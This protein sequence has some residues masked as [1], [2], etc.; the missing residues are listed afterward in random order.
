[1]ST[2][3]D[4]FRIGVW[5]VD[6]RL[7]TLISKD[8][9]QRLAPKLMNLLQQLALS[10]GELV[11][12]EH[13]LEIVW[14]GT[15][16]NDEVVSRA[17]AELRQALGDDAKQ[18][19]F[20]E[21]IPKRGYR[22]IQAVE[23]I[24]ARP[25]M[26]KWPAFIGVLSVLLAVLLIRSDWGDPADNGV[27][28]FDEMRVKPVTSDEGQESDPAISNDGNLAVFAQTGLSGQ[29][30]LWL[31][32]TNTL[33]RR[34][35]TDD[36]YY[37]S[38]PV[39]SADSAR[40]AFLQQG[41]DECSIIVHT[42]LDGKNHTV[43]NCFP[44]LFGLDW[45][46]DGNEMVFISESVHGSAVTRL[47]L[48]TGNTTVVT[49]NTVAGSNDQ[50]PKFSTDGNWINF[51]RGNNTGSELYRIA[52]SGGPAVALTDD[53]RYV[54]DHAWVGDHVIFSSDRL[55]SRRL[56]YLDTQN[57]QISTLGM[58]GINLISASKNGKK[59]VFESAHYT[60]NIY[61]LHFD[62]PE[63]LAEKIISS[64]DYDNYPS[65][66]PG[67]NFI[68]FNSNRSGADSIWIASSSGEDAQMLNQ[69]ADI[70][71]VDPAW[72]ADGS[73]LFATQFDR[74]KSQ[75]LEVTLESRQT[76][77]LEE[78]GGHAYGARVAGQWLYF[79]NWGKESP[80]LARI[81]LVNGGSTENL[82]VNANRV[83][84]GTNGLVYYTKPAKDGIFGL[85][86][87][88]GEEQIIVSDLP[89]DRWKD[90]ALEVPWL[91]YVRRNSNGTY[92]VVRTDIEGNGPEVVTNFAPDT[93]G[94]SMDI[95]ADGNTVFVAR[96]D[97]ADLDIR[98]IDLSE[99]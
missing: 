88:G 4:H 12:R 35:L 87:D 79:I 17:V 9:R 81:P 77:M 94:G 50:R 93:V 92:E 40:I 16:V 57:G 68:A 41:E 1:M 47:N 42:I 90:W 83:L 28:Q 26:L 38:N 31:I 14:G 15:I 56:W 22:L 64:N 54:S 62:Q 27:F 95:S 84:P 37:E 86:P 58:P 39:F 60:A 89:A 23:P 51:I 30:D 2:S 80:Q 75:I 85:N 71:R 5:E 76:R 29:V 33:I 18:P 48:T 74:E 73:K 61:K 91:V 8:T 97:R 21:T 69:T 65:L 7:G 59:L 36:A 67:E 45:S 3:N 49:H 52:T 70:R 63:I 24:N 78:A 6:C 55:G 66:S 32:D 20:I 53:G 25:R 99:N 11:S 34:Q 43:A 96:T 19:T 82:S 13:L 44:G 98:M 10:D 72:S 46:E